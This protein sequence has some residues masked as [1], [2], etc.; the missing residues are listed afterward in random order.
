MIAENLKPYVE[1]AWVKE[2]LAKAAEK[3]LPKSVHLYQKLSLSRP[4]VC[5]YIKAMS[6]DIEDNFKKADKFVNFSLRLNETTGIKNTMQLEIFFQR[7]TSD[8]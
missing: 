2:L 8:F 3:L 5:E 4:T 1:G 7:I 6:Q